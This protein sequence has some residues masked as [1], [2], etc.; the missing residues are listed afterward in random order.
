[1]NGTFSEFRPAVQQT[2]CYFNISPAADFMKVIR[3]ELSAIPEGTFQGEPDS[4]HLHRLYELRAQY[5]DWELGTGYLGFFSPSAGTRYTFTRR[6]EVIQQL[7]PEITPETKVL[8]IGCGAGLFCFELASK[9]N[10]VVGVDIAR[11]VLTFADTVRYVLGKDNVVFSNGD[12]EHLSFRENMF[13]L[14]ICS[15]VMEHVLFPEAVLAEIRRVLKDSGTLILTT[16]TAFSLSDL[17]MRM[18]HVIYR[19]VETEQALHIDKRTYLA[20]Q[21]K[22]R[23][24][25]DMPPSQTFLRIHKRFPQAELLRMFQQ[26]G[27]ESEQAAG[28]I[29]A[30]P[31]HYQVFY[32]VCPA[33]ILSLVRRLEHFLNAVHL[34]GQFGAVTTCFRLKPTS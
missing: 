26:A 31:P 25:R 7:L 10:L 3:D 18:L 13:D 32:R 23:A 14:V 29:F 15:E 2:L 30:F 6:I 4:K 17:S 16:P 21:R 5:L 1:M 28:A 34:F 11:F 27:F 33:T 20:L 24:M 12:A 8:E 9:A 19:H 22:K